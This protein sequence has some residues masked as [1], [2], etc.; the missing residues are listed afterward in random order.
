MASSAQWMR[1]CPLSGAMFFCGIPLLPLLAKTSPTNSPDG[2]PFPPLLTGSW[3]GDQ[4]SCWKNKK[5]IVRALPMTD[6][7]PGCRPSS[8]VGGGV[9]RTPALKW[10]DPT[11]QYYMY[12][13]ANNKDSSFCPA[14]KTSFHPL[15][16][17]IHTYIVQIQTP[18][19]SHQ[20]SQITISPGCDCDDQ[21]KTPIPFHPVQW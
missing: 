13:L 12:E 15:S 2:F 19:D 3:A 1:G 4:Y 6:I 14:D 17:L 5:T 20:E 21:W 10:P 16:S 18:A 8:V 7:V 11:M 9:S